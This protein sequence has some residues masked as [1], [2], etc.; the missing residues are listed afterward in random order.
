MEPRFHPKTTLAALKRERIAHRLIGNVGFS[1]VGH[2][3]DGVQYSLNRPKF[4]VT[5]LAA[6][7]KRAV[8]QVDGW[9]N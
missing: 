9:G 6:R 4:N 5:L 2:G 8:F 1:Y 3:F 7:P